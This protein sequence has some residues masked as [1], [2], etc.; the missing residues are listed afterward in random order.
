MSAPDRISSPV[1][2]ISAIINS[3]P[4]PIFCA[5]RRDAEGAEFF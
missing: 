3:F 1:A 4:Y 5:H 2:M